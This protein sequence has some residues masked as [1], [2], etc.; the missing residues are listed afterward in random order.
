MQVFDKELLKDNRKSLIVLFLFLGLLL[1]VN[2]GKDKISAFLHISKE[3]TNKLIIS[4]IMVS[5]KGVFADSYGNCYDWIELYNGKE[6][7]ISLENYTLNDNEYGNNIWTFPDI[8]IKSHEYKI[9]YLTGLETNDNEGLYVPFALNKDGGEVLTLKSPDGKV[10]ES[11]P[12]KK[13]KKNISLIRN[14]DG[15]YEE[16]KEITPGYENTVEGRKKYLEALEGDKNDLVI[17]EFLPN[18]KGI[19]FNDGKLYPYIELQNK[20]EENISL[21]DY[22]LSDNLDRPFLW[23]LEDKELEP[24]EIYLVYANG[25][26]TFNQTNFSIDK[27]EGELIL[28]YKNKIVEKVSYKIEQSGYAWV[29]EK[30]DFIE[31][32]KITPGYQNTSNGMKE[33]AKSM[34]IS[35]DLILSEIM[36]GNSKYLK[37]K[38]GEYYD[39]IEIY[40]ASD[41]SINLNNYTISTS[42]NN[43]NGVRLPKKTLKP[44]EYYTFVAT[45]QTN[46]SISNNQSYYLYKN[47]EIVDSLYLGETPVGYSY[48]RNLNGGFYYYSTP[49]PN[50]KNSGG[51]LEITTTPIFS[52][53]PGIYNDIKSLSIELNGNGK[54]YYTLDG[55]TPTKKSTLYKKPIVV[56]KTTVIKMIA[57]ED[58]KYPSEVQS[59]SYIINE[60]HTL[61]VMSIS[62]PKSSFQKISNSPGARSLIVKAHAELFEK[63]SSF[64]VDCG[65]KIFGGESRSLDKKSFSLKFSSRFGVSSLKYRVFENRS[66]EKYDNLV[67]RSGSQDMMNSMMR[68]ELGTSIMVDYGNVDAQSYKPVILY[69]NG[70]Y[71]GIYYLREKINDNFIE[72]HYNIDKKGTNIVRIEGRVDEGNSKDYNA[73]LQYVKTHD[74]SITEN[75]NY[76]K[77]K[78][79]IDNYIEFL[80]GQFYTNNFDIRNTRYFNNPSLDNDRIKLIFYDLDYSFRQYPANFITWLL[81]PN[82]AGYFNV[83]NSLIRGLMTNQ[84]FKERFLDIFFY[85]MKYVWTEEHLL[86]RYQEIY[87]AIEPEMKRNQER[88]GYSYETWKKSCEDVKKFIQGREKS[89]LRQVKSYFHLTDKEIEQRM[90][91]NHRLKDIFSHN[92]STILKKG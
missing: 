81:D 9:L 89:M 7:D 54:I 64:S 91:K 56:S 20:G 48:G 36:N 71:W 12:I 82:G 72:Q 45:N 78:L 8:V 59:G 32:I 27:N 33:Y 74:L 31:T 86:N 22:Y 92:R 39:W 19:Y 66:I 58:G 14:S 47:T 57:Y 1:A 80:M 60:N 65:L 84:E 5:N 29:K 13:T 87:D 52:E 6:E 77:S 42:K 50:K 44:G 40:N 3:E 15:E 70:S 88:W 37:Q 79:D 76:V 35:N 83:D 85:N 51:Y 34:K 69:I 23:K 90:N 18:N 24:G 10:V 26:G 63:D 49:T 61:P 46:F 41:K 11:I 2:Y 75:Y 4:E 38:D 17:T 21:K 62:L 55:S 43:K 25:V 30:D 68:D 16:T 67:L 28:S 53:E 73:L